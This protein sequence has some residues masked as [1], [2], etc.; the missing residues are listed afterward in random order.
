MCE[1]IVNEY[2]RTIKCADQENTEIRQQLPT[3]EQQYEKNSRQ[4]EKQINEIA[5]LQAMMPKVMKRKRA[6]NAIDQ[7]K[8]GGNQM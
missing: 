8:R 4:L 5:E 7:I 3:M 1:N 2:R 6:L